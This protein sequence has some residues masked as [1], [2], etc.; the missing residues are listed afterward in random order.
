MTNDPIPSDKAERK[1]WVQET[2]CRDDAID[3]ILRNT[4]DDSEFRVYK[5]NNYMMVGIDNEPFRE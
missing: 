2:L 1:D 3:W 4:S 5:T